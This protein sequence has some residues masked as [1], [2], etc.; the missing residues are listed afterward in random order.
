MN[1][2][3]RLTVTKINVANLGQPRRPPQAGNRLLDQAGNGSSTSKRIRRWAFEHGH[4]PV[5][6]A[7]ETPASGF[8][9]VLNK[10]HGLLIFVTWPCQPP[11]DLPSHSD[12]SAAGKGETEPAGRP[13]TA[14]MSV[15][16]RASASRH[17]H[18]RP[19]GHSEVL[20]AQPE[21]PG[22]R[23]L[24]VSHYEVQD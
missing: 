18:P 24:S 15:S 7:E 5:V 13:D 9:F 20:R 17:D 16:T 6:A 10:P 1:E 22:V 12:S 2:K 19:I 11:P 23:V 8:A 21:S 4:E 3:A 14:L